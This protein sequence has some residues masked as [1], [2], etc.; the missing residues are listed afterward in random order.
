MQPSK[1]STAS[2]LYH[3]WSVRKPQ[4]ESHGGVISTQHYEASR[5][6]CEILARGG[7]A[8][9]AAI[10]AV[11]ALSVVEPW[12]S[13][14][15]G[16]GFLLFA[17]SDGE[18]VT[19]DFGVRA[20]AA[21]QSC[22]YIVEEGKD[23]DWFNWPRVRNNNNLIGPKSICVPG[24]VHGLSAA[25]QRYGSLR[26]D[27][28]I[29][30]TI[31]LAARGMRIDW[32]AELAIANDRDGLSKN[33]AAASA[34]LNQSRWERSPEFPNSY[35]LRLP[36]NLTFLERLAKAGADDFYEGEIAHK[37]LKSLHQ[38]GSRLTKNDLRGYQS[39]WHAPLSVQYKDREVHA[40]PQLSGGPTLLAALAS[41]GRVDLSAAGE[42][43]I[44][45]AYANALI[46]ADRLRLETMG[47][48]AGKDSCTSHVSVVDRKG[49]MVALT[50]TLLSRFGSK[51]MVPDLGILLNNGM[52]WFDPRR[53]RPNSIAPG[54]KPLA[55]MS[56]VIALRGK[57]PE[58]ALG[59]AGGRKIVPAVAQILSYLV[60]LNYTPEEAMHAP[61]IDTSSDTL[62][63]NP[64]FSAET[65][66][67]I[68]QHHKTQIVE[69][70]LLP[71][72][73]AVPSLVTS[74]CGNGRNIGAAHP[75]SPW[76]AAMAES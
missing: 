40:M 65:L 4:V 39:E 8:M 51:V 41:L 21:I 35:F 16:G 62:L 69:D 38:D 46:A 23:G 19:L 24:T 68:A 55:N 76:A 30:P 34:F 71:V 15:G 44:T 47:H 27:E 74:G 20:A 49:N 32:F 25:L 11:F 72:N 10:A 59:A 64:A 36:Q 18:V 57:K 52:M 7:N 54:E 14:L 48:A 28:V 63:M 29:A 9:D 6:G 45:L 75:N 26:W 3:T 73:F 66:Q 70:T 61:R 5:V 31:E 12:L 37:M 33:T 67:S 2:E 43:E 50:N 1:L 42:P 13:G 56:P 58:I 22:D 60:D 53:D 17:N